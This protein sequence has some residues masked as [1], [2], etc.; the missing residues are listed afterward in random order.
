LTNRGAPVAF[1]QIPVKW[2]DGITV[3][4]KIKQLQAI[5]EK[6]RTERENE[7]L[8][9]LENGLNRGDFPATSNIDFKQTTYEITLPARLDDPKVARETLQAV[10]ALDPRYEPLQFDRLYVLCPKDDPINTK[11]ATL[12][13]KDVPAAQA[14]DK[15]AEAVKVQGIDYMQV[16]AMPS[17]GKGEYGDTKITLN[18]VNVPIVELLSRFAVALGPNYTWDM[19]T[20]E[21]YGRHFGFTNFSSPSENH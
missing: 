6:N 11:R 9:I 5:P 16:M 10:A 3:K 2:S 15:L 1:V 14:I 18:L 13:L 7:A 12:V 20:I 17:D 21:G 19:M 4:G 8:K